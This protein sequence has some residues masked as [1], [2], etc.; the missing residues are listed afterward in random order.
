MRNG[1]GWELGWRVVQTLEG[2]APKFGLR[3]ISTARCSPQGS[4]RQQGLGDKAPGLEAED[5]DGVCGTATDSPSVRQG[6]EGARGWKG[7]ASSLREASQS[8]RW[9]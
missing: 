5:L 1:G 6:W 3:L 7:P 2:Q 9:R 4:K 8:G